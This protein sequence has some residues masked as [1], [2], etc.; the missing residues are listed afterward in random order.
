MLAFC[1]RKYS[2]LGFVTRSSLAKDPERFLIATFRAFDP[3]LRQD[4]YL[5]F[6][7]NR[8]LLVLLLH[9]DRA[10]SLLSFGSTFTTDKFPVFGKHK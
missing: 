10:S 4:V 2:C 3:G 8:L 1:T 9:D 7:H 6:E 5:F